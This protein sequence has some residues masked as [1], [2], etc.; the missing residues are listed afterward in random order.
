[1]LKFKRADYDGVYHKFNIKEG[2]WYGVN[3]ETNLPIA[4]S[5]WYI[6][7]TK[8]LAVYT[9]IDGL[10]WALSWEH[11]DE[12]QFA[13]DE[14]RENAKDKLPFREWIEKMGYSHIDSEEEFDEKE[15]YEEYDRYL[16]GVE[17]SEYVRKY[18]I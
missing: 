16:Y 13:L 15:Y 7:N 9:L 14:Y 5:G 12:M 17:L 10:W 8:E 4:T 6:E 11:Y 18:F 3:T 1:M 2:Y